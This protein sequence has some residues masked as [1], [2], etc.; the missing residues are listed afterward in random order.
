MKNILLLLCILLLGEISAQSFAIGHRNVIYIDPSR[1]NRQIETEIYYPANI[2]GDNVAIAQGQ[3]PVISFGHGFVMVWSAYQN[4][5]SALVPQGY[6]VM[7]P[8]TEGNT[9]PSHAEFGR[10][11]AFLIGKMQTEGTTA[12]SPFFGAVGAT[13][14]IMGH[15]M[16]G[17]SSFLAVE[18]NTTITTMIT[19]AAANTNPSSIAAASNISVPSLVIAGENDC[20]APP[21]QHQIPMYNGL[22]SSCKTYVE[23]KGGGHCYFANNNFNCSFGEGTCTPN[24]TITR[25]EQQDATQ[26]LMNLWLAYFLKGDCPS[27]ESFGD[28]LLTSPRITSQSTCLYPPPVVTINANVLTSSPAVTYQWMLNNA[29]IPGADSSSYTIPGIGSYH[30]ET[31][32]YNSCVYVS[33]PI[34][35]TGTG[36]TDTPS[37]FE[38]FPNPVTDAVTLIWNS[39]SVIPDAVQIIGINGVV[40][41]VQQVITGNTTQIQVEDL[42][43]GF[44]MIQPLRNGHVLTT[45]KMIK[46]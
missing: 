23:V 44:Y 38:I 4:I 27:W 20:V 19:L 24:P 8:R 45:Q 35:I 10:D 46:Q 7:F 2:A 17:G 26:D 40:I 34:V 37:T 42:A 14:A 39:G 9:S 6:I 29:A 21:A 3:F 28:S 15:S 25:A 18:N 36:E 11:L 41:K 43:P 32:Y 16:G 22:S 1:N 12:N 30:V 31:T 33:A 13:S 5:W